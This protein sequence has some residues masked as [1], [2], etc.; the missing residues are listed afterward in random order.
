MGQ[1]V[2]A[3]EAVNAK[4]QALDKNGANSKAAVDAVVKGL[5]SLQKMEG[6]T[7][8]VLTQSGVGKKVKDL[9]KHQVSE[10]SAAAKK[11]V[12]AWKK[13]VLQS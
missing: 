10:I 3:W 5:S 6:V 8:D 9:S 4:I 1:V 7:A 13:A 2:D 11:V 12:Q